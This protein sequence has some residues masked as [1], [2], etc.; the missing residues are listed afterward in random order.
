MD[1]FP[2]VLLVPYRGVWLRQAAASMTHSTTVWR[3]SCWFCWRTSPCCC[4]AFCTETRRLVPLRTVMEQPG[5]TTVISGWSASYLTLTT[6]FCLRC[7][8]FFLWNGKRHQ[9][10][11]SPNIRRRPS[12]WRGVCP[13]VCGAQ[14]RSHLLLGLTQGKT[15]PDASFNI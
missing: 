6:P 14:P 12:G 13:A 9:L 11:D 1:Y 4:W 15:E 3:L 10:V 5:E 8:T 2:Q 7:P